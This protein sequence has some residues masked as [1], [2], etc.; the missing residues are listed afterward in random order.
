MIAEFPDVTAVFAANDQTALGLITAFAQN[1]VSVPQQMSVV[2]F[3]NQDETEFYNPALTTVAQDFASLGQHAMKL[4]LD[5]VSGSSSAAHEDV[6]PK[7]VV[8]A[9]T[10]AP[11]K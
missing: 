4:L 3:D 6:L 8:R 10:A 7:L 9:S 2:G 11:N 1:G 5:S